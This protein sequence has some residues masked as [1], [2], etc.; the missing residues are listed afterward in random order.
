LVHKTKTTKTKTQHNICWT[1]LHKQTN[2][3]NIN[4][5]CDLL[6]PTGGKGEPNIV[7][8]RKS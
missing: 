5:I 2:T 6:Q 4:K 3:N 1:S 7:C 8:M